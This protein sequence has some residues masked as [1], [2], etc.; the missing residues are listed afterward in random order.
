[1]RGVEEDEGKEESMMVYSYIV[2]WGSGVKGFCGE[3]YLI[4]YLWSMAIEV[5]IIWAYLMYYLVLFL[6]SSG[7]PILSQTIFQWIFGSDSM[8]SKVTIPSMI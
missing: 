3:G 5:R 6:K 8:F 4:F 2:F 7:S 1:M